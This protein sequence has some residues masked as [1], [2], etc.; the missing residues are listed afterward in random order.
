MN[1]SLFLKLGT[2]ALLILLLMIPLLLIDGLVNERQSLRNDVLRDIARSSSYQQQITGPILVVPYSKTVQQWKTVA[3]SS[4]RY[5]EKGVELG[6]LYF[7][8]ERFALDGDVRTELRYRGIYQARL[9]HSDS[10]VSGEFKVPAHYGVSDVEA[11]RF[12]DPF[13]AVGISDV[14][15]IGNDLKLQLNGASLSFEPG[16]GDDRFGSGVHVPL[17][18]HDGRDEQ[19]L[20]FAFDLKLQG[21]EQLS[22]TPVGRESQVTL[23]SD[24]PHP[25]F[26][27]E[28]LPSQREV[29]EQGFTAN[30]QT[31][32]FATDMQEALSACVSGSCSAMQ[33]RVFGVS[34]IEPV[35]QY[36]KADR[37]IKYALLFVTLT[38]AVF[39]LFEV[40][41]RLAVHPVQYALVG[42]SLALF[43][44]LLLSLSEHLGFAIAYGLSAL[45]C[46]ALNIFYVS[47]VLRSWSR[48]GAFGVLLA[49]LYGLL[50][51]LLG[52]EDYALLMGSLLVFGVLGCVMVLTRK[53]D[54]YGVGR[55][56]ASETV[57]TP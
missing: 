31:S 35:D 56:A 44:L 18:A 16:S 38:F 37:A 5:L 46:V 6:R 30:W 40:L 45:G 43:Y 19:T 51:G 20:V 53:L 25:S 3:G 32:F 29:T 42:L 39:F 10:Q 33:N 54:W 50:Y 52:A 22:I 36:L 15:G 41:K 48:G 49:A 14:R 4:E 23:R 17:P 27:G 24:W 55:P 12:D 7:L 13:I 11:Y 26:V 34:F 1:R 2:I 47:S 57:V 9:Y 21:T 28:Y 8:P